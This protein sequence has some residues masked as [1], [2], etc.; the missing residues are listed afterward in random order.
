MK[1][2]G[3]TPGCTF[4]PHAW[5]HIAQHVE[6]ESKILVAA[7]QPEEL[8]CVRAQLVVANTISLLRGAVQ[9]GKLSAFFW[10]DTTM[11]SIVTIGQPMAITALATS[12]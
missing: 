11:P 4:T 3:E 1:L 5:L 12:R 9:L 6:T 10:P 7:T 2:Y 8:D